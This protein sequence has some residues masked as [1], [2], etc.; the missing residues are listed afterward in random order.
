MRVPPR[1]VAFGTPVLHES[2]RGY[3]TIGGS[4]IGFRLCRTRFLWRTLSVLGATLTLATALAGAVARLAFGRMRTGRSGRGRGL[5]WFALPVGA[6]VGRR[7]RHA[8]QPLDVTQIGAFLVI[9]ERDRE[10]LG[11]G[12][13]G[14]ADAVDVAFRHIG[15]VVIDDMRDAVDIDA[16]RGDIGGDQGLDLAVAEGGKRPLAL[17]L[18]LVAVDGFGREALLVELAPLP[19]LGVPGWWPDNEAQG[20][21]DNSDYFRPGRA[22]LRKS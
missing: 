21:Y 22:G 5:A 12:A 3:R 10:A 14:A 6:L 1:G 11:A 9:A 4:A 18:R 2:D 17:A 15:Q 19:V 13:R 7:Q 8:N 20:F 16:A